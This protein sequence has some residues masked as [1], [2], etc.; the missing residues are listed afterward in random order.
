M[1]HEWEKKKKQEKKTKKRKSV[2]TLPIKNVYSKTTCQEIHGSIGH[3]N[4]SHLLA[5]DVAWWD[6]ASLGAHELWLFPT[7]R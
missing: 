5:T 1:A 4:Y 7:K 6:Q 2:N 3:S